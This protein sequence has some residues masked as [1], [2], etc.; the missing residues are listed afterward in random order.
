MT[1]WL[2]A[3]S[4]LKK[5]DGKG[6]KKEGEAV[7][8]FGLKILHLLNQSLANIEYAS[9]TLGKLFMLDRFNIIANEME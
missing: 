2:W 9:N 7:T 6:S 5:E 4:N 8:T 3:Q 1:Q